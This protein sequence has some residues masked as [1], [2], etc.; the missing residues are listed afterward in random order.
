M[1]CPTAAAA[2]GTF[3]DIVQD[4]MAPVAAQPLAAQGR[5]DRASRSA[6]ARVTAA[7]PPQN[8]T[9][10]DRASNEAGTDAEEQAEGDDD[11]D[12]DVLSAFFLGQQHKKPRKN[13]DESPS[14]GALRVAAKAAMN[15]QADRMRKQAS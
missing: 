4:E 11:E 5:P 6:A 3:S 12:D 8:N 1:S 10:R 7:R 15:K 14:R 2:G 13:L 9:M